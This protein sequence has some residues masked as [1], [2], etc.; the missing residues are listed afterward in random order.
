M[1]TENNNVIVSI[2]FGHFAYCLHKFDTILDYQLVYSLI[3]IASCYQPFYF[4]GTLLLPH[5][6]S[7]Y[8]KQLIMPYFP[9]V[10]NKKN[11]KLQLSEILTL[12]LTVKI[13]YLDTTDILHLNYYVQHRYYKIII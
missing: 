12:T 5:V 10:I 8:Q 1:S 7:F 6:C 11:I 3:A 9:L 4:C 13:V 2:T